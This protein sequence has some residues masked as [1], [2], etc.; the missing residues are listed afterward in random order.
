MATFTKEQQIATED[1]LDLASKELKKAERKFMLA[2]NKYA[3]DDAK[4]IKARAKMK[5]A[6]RAYA[7]ALKNL[8]NLYEPK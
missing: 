4:V 3:F 2:D 7:V 1:A 8:A 6:D 5:D